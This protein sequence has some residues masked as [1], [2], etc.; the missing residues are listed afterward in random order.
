MRAVQARAGTGLNLVSMWG[1]HIELIEKAEHYLSRVS[2]AG[3]RATLASE[4]SHGDQRKLEV[5]ILL[6]L[7]PAIFMF[8]LYLIPFIPTIP[9]KSALVVMMC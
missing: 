9:V 5:A 1:R 4:L 3:R 7:E 6:A 2:L 8:D